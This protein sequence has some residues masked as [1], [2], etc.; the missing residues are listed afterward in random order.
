MEQLNRLATNQSLTTFDVR[1]VHMGQAS[2]RVKQA[3]YGE[4]LADLSDIARFASRTRHD[5]AGASAKSRA[6]PTN[7]P[8]SARPDTGGECGKSRQS[9][10]MSRM[11]FR[12]NGPGRR[13]QNALA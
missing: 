11:Q 3:L 8:Q 12:A 4:G 6:Y 13:I 5:D 2:I 9:V 7:G 1:P 10:H